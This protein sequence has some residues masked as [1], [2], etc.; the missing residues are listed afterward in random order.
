MQISQ[1]NQQISELIKEEYQ[2]VF[3]LSI[4]T[5]P[6]PRKECKAITM[7]PEEPQPQ[8]LQE[9]TKDEQFTQFLETFKKLHINISF[10]ERKLP[11]KMPNPRSFLIPCTIRNIIFE[12]VLCD[13]GSSIKLMPLTVMKKLE[14]QEVQPTR[15]AL[16][17]A[18]KSRKQAYGLLENVLVKIG[19][20]FFPTD[21]VILDMGE[22]T[23]ESIILGR[24]FL[25]IGRALIDVKRDKLVLR[26]HEDRTVFKVFKPPLPPD[27]RGTCMQSAM[28]KPPPLVETNTVPLDIKPKFGVG[29]SPPTKERESPMGKM[30]R[31]W[32][33][34][35]SL[36][37]TSH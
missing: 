29:H 13:L 14:I 35:K 32:R 12:K 16:K 37:K 33:N 8:K 18:D 15:I 19:E 5:V 17:M 28:L 22:G 25:A 36:L 3:T 6:T 20:L 21:F 2:A 30:L 23:D 24:P 11:K 1:T 4:D 27:K 34:K 9:E 10:A 7:E 31:R 26:L